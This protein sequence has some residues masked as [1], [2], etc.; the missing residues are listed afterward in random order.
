M[1]GYLCFSVFAQPPTLKEFPQAHLNPTDYRS[2]CSSL[3]K[4]LDFSLGSKI[5]LPAHIIEFRS[6]QWGNAKD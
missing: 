3:I 5:F 2:I 4:R 6:S 1:L